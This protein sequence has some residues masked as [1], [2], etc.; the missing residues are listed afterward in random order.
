MENDYKPD[1]NDFDDDL[2]HNLFFGIEEDGI[3]YSG[4]KPV[5]V[6][7]TYARMIE[8][9][10]ISITRAGVRSFNAEESEPIPAG[11]IAAKAST[12][13]SIAI[14][15]LRSV[16]QYLDKHRVEYPTYKNNSPSTGTG[17]FIFKVTNN[18]V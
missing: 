13:R 8:D 16:E 12:A 11:I 14:A 6:H 10:S 4:L 5:L 1:T 15:Y 2:Y 9:I 18:D 7:Y 17:A 3:R